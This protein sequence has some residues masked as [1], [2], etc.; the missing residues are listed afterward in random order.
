LPGTEEEYAEAPISDTSVT[1]H[2]E[3]PYDEYCDYYGNPDRHVVLGAILE[4][5]IPACACCGHKARVE[6]V[7]SVWGID[8]MD[9]DPA[10]TQINI[11]EIGLRASG[12]RYALD[13][14]NL[15]GCLKDVAEELYTDEAG[16]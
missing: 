9:D 7:G 1:P 12:S 11:G 13:D 15:A 14:A 3:I 2:R 8:V 16:E 10:L 4:K 5:A 6:T